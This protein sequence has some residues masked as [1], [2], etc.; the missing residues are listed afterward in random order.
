MPFI[1]LSSVIGAAINTLIFMETIHDDKIKESCRRPVRTSPKE[2]VRRIW[3]GMR[4]Q[5]FGWYQKH[6]V[7]MGAYRGIHL[8]FI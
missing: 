2:N 3:S 7:H 8:S 4:I 6:Q 5:K 1:I